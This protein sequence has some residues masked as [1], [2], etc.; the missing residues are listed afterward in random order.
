MEPASK[1]DANERAIDKPADDPHI[2]QS[3]N[4]ICLVM[5]GLPA[6]GKSLIAGKGLYCLP[7]WSKSTSLTDL[8]SEAIP[9]L[10][11]CPS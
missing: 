5:V 10:D 8:C 6:R 2:T 4:Q 3:E 7:R 11:F 9:R 1:P